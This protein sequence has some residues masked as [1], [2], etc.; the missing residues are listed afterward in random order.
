M[1]GSIQI[2][3][4]QSIL[5]VPDPGRW[6]GHF[7]SDEPDAIV[8]RIGLYLVHCHARPSHESRSPPNGGVKRRE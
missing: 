3:V 8:A 6:I 4:I 7:V 2:L 1:D 5:I